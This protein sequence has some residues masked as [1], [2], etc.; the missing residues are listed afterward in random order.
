MSIKRQFVTSSIWVMVGQGASNIA[1][2][3][4]FAVLARLLGPADFGVVAF[5]TVFVDLSRSIALAGLPA[6]LVKEKEWSHTLA[7]TAFWGNVFFSILIAA[8]VGVG[9]AHVMGEFYGNDI[10]LV[11]MALAVSLV[12]DAIR[13][14]HEAKLQREF[15]FKSLAK[16]T[17][18][19]TTGAGIIGIILA[20]NGFGV[21]ALVINRLSNSIIQTL[22][23]WVAAKWTPGVVFERSKFTSLFKFGMHLSTSAVFGQINRRVPELISGFLIGPIAVGYYKVGARI[24]GIITELTITPMQ[25]TAMASFS[26]LNNNDSLIRGFLKVTNMVGLISFPAF[27]G[28]AVLAN[29]LI[30]VML[31]EKWVQSGFVLS[32]LALIGGAATLSYFVQPLLAAAG[33]AHLASAR[34]LLTLVSNSIVCLATAPFG[35]VPMATAF[36]IRAYV[37]I[38]PTVYLLKSSLGLDPKVALKGL[39]P[40]FLSAAAMALVLLGF[41]FYFGESFNPIQRIL[42]MVPLGAAVYV[43]FLLIF[44]R[45]FVRKNLKELNEIRASLKR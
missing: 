34:S 24:V 15:K 6:A 28:I 38:I 1:S 18:F 12:I 43:I 9:F 17:A 25:A 14:T 45:N 36:M 8:V 33:K 7:S 35:I 41:N 30:F 13:A 32:T 39:M 23:V 3:V 31:G 19:A 42:M 2:F 27:F 22:I 29:D 40:S 16:R 21:W 20:F 11:I 5:A 10:K 44:F 4:I 37:G 26:R